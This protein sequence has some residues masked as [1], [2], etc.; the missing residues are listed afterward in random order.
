MFKHVLVVFV[1]IGLLPA[2]SLAHEEPPEEDA[3]PW[4]GSVSFGYLATSGNTDNSNLNGSFTLGYT[5][6]QWDHLLE[7]FAINASESNANTAESYGIGGKSEYNMSEVSYLFGRLYYRND[8]F[9]GF[10]TQFTA[11]AGYG[12]RFIETPA[13]ALSADAGIGARKSE[14]ADGVDENDFIVNG[15][16]NYKWTFSETANFTQRF[17]VEYGQNNTFFESD[18]AITARLIG[19]LALVAS[20]NIKNNSTVPAG[21]E[22]TDTFSAIALEYAF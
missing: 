6:G 5:S 15:S 13:H 12:R 21:I 16:L 20:F 3:G 22:K 7:A 4:S 2:T 17:L 10:P 18:S 1:A 14:R 8:R 19:Q 11:A 9:S